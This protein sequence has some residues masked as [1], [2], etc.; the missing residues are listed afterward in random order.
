MPRSKFMLPESVQSFLL[1]D[2]VTA[3]TRGLA[4]ANLV[5]NILIVGTGGLVRLTGSGLGCPTWPLCTTESLVPTQEMGI[6]GLIEF[7]NRT[8]TGLLVIVAL[9][10]YLAVRNAPKQLG[11]R[12][13][14]FL[15]G[16][17]IIVQAIIGGITVIFHLDPR[18]VG[19]HFLFSAAIVAIA[20]LL[21][22]RVRYAE[23]LP[24]ADAP[25]APRGLWVS[26]IVVTV[27][28]WITE[29]V[30]VLTTGAGPHAG[31]TIAARNGFDPVVMQHVHSWPAYALAAAL[32]V[33]MV[34]VLRSKLARTKASSV[35]LLI[36]VVIQIAFGVYQSR[37]GLPVWSVG[38]H[39]I[40]AVTVIAV[41]TVNL[42]N[43]R[44]AK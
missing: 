12:I 34:F 8:L 19:V 11:L 6:H 43:A 5:V 15:I 39:M 25:R 17:L 30:G 20:A 13:P 10:T 18:I 26:L 24:A 1:P 2:S 36:L 3:W 27:L 4:W 33:M 29:V 21:L 7:G 28:T 23:P 32:V 41:L 37:A 16:V 35:T 42:V 40:L 9:L 22:Q 38:T 31:D 44:R 14:A